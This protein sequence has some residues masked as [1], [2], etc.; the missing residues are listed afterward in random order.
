MLFL[1]GGNYS[2]RRDPVSAACLLLSFA[3]R[4]PLRTIDHQYHLQALR[5][6]YVL[7]AEPRALHTIDVDSGLTVSVNVQVELVDGRVL[8][9]LAPGLLPELSTIRRI[10]VAPPEDSAVDDPAA[11]LKI[12]YYPTSIELQK[13][14]GGDLQGTSFTLR[15]K[16]SG[17]RSRTQDQIS[18]PPLFVKQIPRPSYNTAPVVETAPVVGVS[19]LKW[20]AQLHHLVIPRSFKEVHEVHSPLVEPVCHETSPAEQLGS[21]LS[22]SEGARG[23]EVVLGQALC[24]NEKF[25]HLILESMTS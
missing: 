13:P 24:K 5:H 23:A 20:M 19:E 9:M 25:L 6:L 17:P 3:P 14:S 8:S 22:G 2:L 7:A 18:V 21:L 1:G 10:S 11:P 16:S 15:M 12:A 4:F